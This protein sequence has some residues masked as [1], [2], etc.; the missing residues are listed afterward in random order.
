MKGEI[1]KKVR[2][3]QDIT[4]S[5]IALRL[6]VDQTSVVKIEN[7]IPA[8]TREYIVRVC[9]ILSIDENFLE[10]KSNYLFLPKSFLK[11]RISGIKARISPL[12]W[13]DLI[14]SYS[15]TAK[16]LLL[17]REN[18]PQLV[19]ACIKDDRNSIFFVRIE[20]PL[21]FQ[22]V[23]DYVNDLP[24][25]K[26]DT[27]YI[28]AKSFF[29]HPEHHLI[30]S[31]DDIA[32]Y[33]REAVN[34]LIE[35]AFVEVLTEKE[36]ELI[37]KI[38]EKNIDLN[39]LLKNLK[40]EETMA[41]IRYKNKTTS[42]NLNALLQILQNQNTK[43]IIFFA[44]PE[45]KTADMSDNDGPE[46]NL[47]LLAAL[48]E[49]EISAVGIL[50]VVFDGLILHAARKPRYLEIRELLDTA[51][52]SGKTYFSLT[53][54]PFTSRLI[55]EEAVEILLN[56]GTPRPLNKQSRITYFALLS[57]FSEADYRNL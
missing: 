54:A 20:I 11:F 15:N 52:K 9:K 40:R 47:P 30:S 8:L 31:F 26:R 32:H 53:R 45:T 21:T 6:A 19:G 18:K 50:H 3:L 25:S 49:I 42:K 14:L 16:V 44:S 27:I 43:R 37:L 36:K 35:N 2:E 28:L 24:E 57:T 22:K 1:L 4:Q 41:V 46:A 56:T 12:A 55:P 29:M 5:E 38:R 10:G 17:T 13:L 48:A 39:F 34:S 33:D 7:N 51:E 23:F